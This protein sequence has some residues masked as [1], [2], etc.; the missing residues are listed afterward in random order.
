MGVLGS[1]LTGAVAG[2]LGLAALSGIITN[3]FDDNDSSCEPDADE[4]K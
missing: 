1:F 2:V 4:E 3:F